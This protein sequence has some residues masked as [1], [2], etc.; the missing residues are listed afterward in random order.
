MWNP[1]DVHVGYDGEQ[2][3]AVDVLPTL[4]VDLK[5]PYI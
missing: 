2:K 4:D 1:N 3:A 5:T